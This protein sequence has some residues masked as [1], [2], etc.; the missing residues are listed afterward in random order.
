MSALLLFC[1]FSFVSLYFNKRIGLDFN[2]GFILQF[3]QCSPTDSHYTLTLNIS[4][5]NI[6]YYANFLYGAGAPSDNWWPS[7]KN[8][9][10]INKTLS[11]VQFGNRDSYKFQWMT[12][13]Y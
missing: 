2:N 9:S 7:A 1:K 11:T 3:G 6:T 13:G 5:T 12:V 10:T 8:L 4:H